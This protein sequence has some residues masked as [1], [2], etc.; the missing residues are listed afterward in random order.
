MRQKNQISQLLAWSYLKIGIPLFIICSGGN[1]F[2]I[3]A[4]NDIVFDEIDGIVVIE[5]ESTS[6]LGN[7]LADTTINHYTGDRYLLYQGMNWF[8]SPGKSL[9]R[10]KINRIARGND[11]TEHNDSWLRIRHTAGFY[12]EKSGNRLYPKG[13]G[14]APNPDGSG[15]NGWFKTYQNALNRWTWNTSTNDHNPYAIYV[16]FDTAGIY[17]IE[18][19]GRSNGHAIDRMVLYHSDISTAVAT[20]ENLP[21]S[22]V[23]STTSVAELTIPIKF[24]PNPAEDYIEI[25]LPARAT[26]TEAPNGQIVDLQGHIVANFYPEMLDGHFLKVSIKHLPPG[27]YYLMLPT[28]HALYLGKLTKI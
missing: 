8:N 20:N 3:N 17:T 27:I 7:W 14:M 1:W 11:N 2:S 10:Y 23:S 13:S 5:A 19:S 6:D 28:D 9:L 26:T 25:S 24:W 21:Q 16:E 4:Q 12:A 18:I 22:P 15:S